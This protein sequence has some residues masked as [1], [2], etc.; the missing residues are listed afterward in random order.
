MQSAGVLAMLCSKVSTLLPL[1]NYLSN[2]MWELDETPVRPCKL[3]FINK[4]TPWRVMSH[5]ESRQM[6]K[7]KAGQS[8]SPKKGQC[9]KKRRESSAA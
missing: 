5:A 1:K 7:G 4:T 6:E 2:P 9:L 3:R 8:N